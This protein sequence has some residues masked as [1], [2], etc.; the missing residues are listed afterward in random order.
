[1]EVVQQEEL[2]LQVRVGGL[3][4]AVLVM[5]PMPLLITMH[6]TGQRIGQHFLHV[7]RSNLGDER[8]VKHA[9]RDSS[10]TA[11]S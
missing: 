5:A 3:T 11:L 9:N 1:M 10:F 2:H 8:H 7:H 4:L 6:G